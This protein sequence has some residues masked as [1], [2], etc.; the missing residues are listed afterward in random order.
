MLTSRETSPKALQLNRSNGCT[1]CAA[2]FLLLVFS[3]IVPCPAQDKTAW[4]AAVLVSAPERVRGM[5]GIGLNSIPGY[6]GRYSFVTEKTEAEKNGKKV[7]VYFTAAEMPVFGSWQPFDAGQNRAYRAGRGVCVYLHGEK[8][9]VFIDFGDEPS[10]DNLFVE[11]F[12]NQMVFFVKDEAAFLS[13]SFPAVI[14][15]Q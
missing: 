1:F 14:E 7:T 12:L 15:L 13:S 2:A 9:A 6:A 11:R 4:Q 10:V 3:G 5:P 8:W